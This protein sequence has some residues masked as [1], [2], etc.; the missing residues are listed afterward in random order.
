MYV[1]TPW[2]GVAQAPSFEL[3]PEAK[4]VYDIVREAQ[5]APRAPVV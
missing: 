1:G 4:R 5:S 3:I 2:P